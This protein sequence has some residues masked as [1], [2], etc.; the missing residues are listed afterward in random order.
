MKNVVVQPLYSDFYTRKDFSQE[1]RIAN[2][3]M[4]LLPFKF[5]DPRAKEMPD[6]GLM[7]VV[8]AETGH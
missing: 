4:I 6:V 1:L 8:D 2:K 5:Y 7:K 3:S